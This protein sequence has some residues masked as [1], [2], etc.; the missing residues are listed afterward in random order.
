MI[1]IYLNNKS[2]NKNVEIN[3]E[4]DSEAIIK[5]ERPL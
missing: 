3:M 2:Q 1:L 4:D 5:E